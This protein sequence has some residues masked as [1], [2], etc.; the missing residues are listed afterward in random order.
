MCETT[1]TTSTNEVKNGK[2]VKLAL[3]EVVLYPCGY[4]VLFNCVRVCCNATRPWRLHVLDDTHKTQIKENR[5]MTF[6]F[7]C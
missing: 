2:S 6:S 4:S 1:T 5:I 7:F 3:A